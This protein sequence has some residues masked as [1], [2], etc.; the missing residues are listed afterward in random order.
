MPETLT[1]TDWQYVACD[2]CHRRRCCRTTAVAG[3]VNAPA[4]LCNTCRTQT[5][6]GAA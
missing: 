5:R 2:R 6:G 3:T 1:R 4:V